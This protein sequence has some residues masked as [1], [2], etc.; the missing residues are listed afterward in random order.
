MNENEKYKHIAEDVYDM[1][2]DH[3]KVLEDDLC[4]ENEITMDNLL[5]VYSQPHKV[6]M[7]LEN[8][9]CSTDFDRDEA[10]IKQPYKLYK[11]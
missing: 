10:I 3:Q 11:G 5:M 9:I 6:C 2:I 4:R 8:A 7:Y 1:Y